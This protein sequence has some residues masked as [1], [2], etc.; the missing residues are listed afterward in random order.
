M[1]PYRSHTGLIEELLLLLLVL[2]LLHLLLLRV[3][4][5]RGEEGGAGRRLRA[6]AGFRVSGGLSDLLPTTL[7]LALVSAIERQ[8]AYIKLPSLL[9]LYLQHTA[10]SF[11]CKRDALYARCINTRRPSCH[12]CGAQKFEVAPRYL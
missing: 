9:S 3:Q 11:H 1:V 8:Q 6:S 2:L 4:E 7:A 5:E 10:N 12:P